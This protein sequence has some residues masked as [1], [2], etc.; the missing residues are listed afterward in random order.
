MSGIGA[1][2]ITAAA[3]NG[4]DIDRFSADG[5][6]AIP[7]G[8]TLIRRDANALASG[9]SRVRKLADERPSILNLFDYLAD[10][11]EG[12]RMPVH[13]RGLLA[14]YAAALETITNG[15]TSNYLRLLAVL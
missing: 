14:E 5:E 7:I 8:N 6:L 3:L 11:H 1:A 10:R 9:G 4:F 15:T 12:S 2:E 13:D